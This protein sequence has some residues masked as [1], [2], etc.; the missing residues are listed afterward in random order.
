MACGPVPRR[1]R[2]ASRR[3]SHEAR[4]LQGN[5]RSTQA[6]ALACAPMPRTPR[7]LGDYNAGAIDGV[8]VTTGGGDALGERRGD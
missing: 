6:E 2:S 5:G 3:R 8:R 1:E 7:R 4:L